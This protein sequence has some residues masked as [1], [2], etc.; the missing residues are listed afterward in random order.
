MK[1]EVLHKIMRLAVFNAI[2]CNLR[3]KRVKRQTPSGIIDVNIHPFEII[4]I[5]GDDALIIVPGDQ[6]LNVS[7]TLGKIFE[8]KLAEHKEFSDNRTLSVGAVIA[9][10]HNPIYFLRYLAE[11]LLKSAKNLVR[12]RPHM[13]Q[14]ALDFLILRS[15]TTISTDLSDLRARFG[16][17]TSEAQR[18]KALLTGRPF[19]WDDLEKL[20]ET[21]QAVKRVLS[22]TQLQAFRR[23]LREGRLASTEFYLYQLAR[24]NDREKKLLRWVE[25]K[26]GIRPADCSPPWIKLDRKGEYDRY[27]TIWEDIWE[28]RDLVPSM[29]ETAWQRIESSIQADEEGSIKCESKLT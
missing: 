18:E 27:W 24:A 16:T 23:S 10:S 20:K 19:S 28:I 25:A 7:I 6:T 15:Q 22:N 4:T 21:T 29:D 12:E 1:S 13:K 17:I 9:D 5:G 11:D 14:G 3:I 2:G 26:W 8:A